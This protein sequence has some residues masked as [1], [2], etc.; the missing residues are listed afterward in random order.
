MKRALFAGAALI[1]LA[2]T[3]AAWADEAADREAIVRR[4][5]ERSQ[6]LE[7]THFTVPVEFY[8]QWLQ[9]V[10]EEAG[11]G[12]LPPV[13]YVDEL[14]DYRLAVPAEGPPTLRVTRRLRV[15]RPQGC[16]N[17]PL[18]SAE[19]SWSRVVVNGKA[20]EL[21]PL[22]GWLCLSPTEPGLVE[23]V[24]ELTLRSGNGDGGQATARVRPAVRNVLEFDSPQAW[25][26]HATGAIGNLV[27]DAEQGTRGRLAMTPSETLQVVYGRPK[28]KYERTPRYEVR[29][30]VAWNF[31][32]AS[33]Q[34]AADLV[35]TVAD[36]RSDQIDLV[37]PSA[38]DR[39]T[40]TGPDVREVHSSSGAA[41]VFLRQKISG[42]TRLQV[43]CELPKRQGGLQSLALPVVR[44][45]QWTDG[46]LV[47]T[48]TAGG[49]EVVPESTSGLEPLALAD[50][51][52]SA[53]AMLA[54]KAVL[55]YRIA[56]R[57]SKVDVNIL[58][59]SAYALRET[60]ADIAH[61]QLLL[62]GDGTVLCKASFEIR[63]RTRQFLEVELPPGAVV[64]AA[65]VNEQTRPM[66]LMP[67]RPDVYLL[68]LERSTVSVE[69]LISF[70]VEIVCLYRIDRLGRGR[71]AL[72]VP[73]I[74]LP[75]AYA[76]AELYAPDNLSRPQWSGPLERVD[77]YASKT[78]KATLGYGR[79]E[80]AAGGT[81]FK[82]VDIQGTPPVTDE[83]QSG[84]GSRLNLSGVDLPTS[85]L[86]ARNYYRAGK[87]FYDKGEFNKAVEAFRKTVELAPESVYAGN[88]ALYMG[89]AA[90]PE[91]WSQDGDDVSKK[92]AMQQVKED[93]SA[94]NLK[95][96][97]QQ[98]EFL[99]QGRQAAQTGKAAEAVEQFRAAVALGEKLVARGESKRE[100]D[101][102]LR[103]V[104]ARLAEVDR[105]VAAQTEQMWARV[106]QLK[107]QGRYEEALNTIRQMR[108]TVQS[109][110][111]TGGGSTSLFTGEDADGDRINREL[112]ELVVKAAGAQGKGASK[113][114]VLTQNEMNRLLTQQ[115]STAP[116]TEGSVETREV[117]RGMLPLTARVYTYPN[118]EEWRDLT[119]RRRRMV[120][121]DEKAVEL[122]QLTPEL[123]ERL[124]RLGVV[125]GDQGLRSV[126]PGDAQRG[127]Q[128]QEQDQE[129]RELVRDR[130]GRAGNGQI[131]AVQDALRD[132][133]PTQPAAA[134]HE[135][136]PT[137]LHRVDGNIDQAKKLVMD[138]LDAAPGGR[139]TKPGIDDGRPTVAVSH[140]SL[141][142]KGTGEQ[143]RQVEALIEKLQAAQGPQV[144]IGANI[145]TQ[146]AR[147]VIT[148]TADTGQGAASLD[149]RRP[150]VG[151]QGMDLT[152]N[153]TP[154]GSPQEQPAWNYT[155]LPPATAQP[156]PKLGDMPVMGTMFATDGN[157]AG[158]VAEDKQFQEFISRN[159]SWAMNGEVPSGQPSLRRPSG[160]SP[161][162]GFRTANQPVPGFGA[163]R[164]AL[165]GADGTMTI[166]VGGG[167]FIADSFEGRRGG[168]LRGGMGE[169][170][171]PSS[172]SP[173]FNQWY[174]DLRYWVAEEPEGEELVE[175]SIDHVDLSARYNVNFRSEGMMAFD[176]PAATSLP[177]AVRTTTA[178]ISTGELKGFLAGKAA[179][180]LGQKVP[181]NS[182]NLNVMVPEVRDLGI[183]FTSGNN[184]VSFTVIDEAQMRTLLELD[185][186]QDIERRV[187]GNNE[188]FQEAL[189][190]TDAQFA[191]GWTGNI[192]FGGEDY[193]TVN[194]IGNPINLPHEKYILVDN[195]RYLTAIRAGE[196]QHWT[197]KIDAAGIRFAEVP[198]TIDVPHVGQFI[199]FEKRL[200]KP[201][202]RL[203]IHCD[204]VWKGATE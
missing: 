77:E 150:V 193:N 39:V 14:A 141:V 37:L 69:G 139:V 67:G 145:I 99:E 33:Q 167:G 197:E 129:V 102:L 151:G 48:S 80:K 8:R 55:A 5:L 187:I 110:G 54:G 170:P 53:S 199:K 203:A 91:G 122:E 86:L 201:T 176:Q 153:V 22:D 133:K 11:Q 161:S 137:V 6:L 18:V 44:D 185:A 70:P 78:A 43:R 40:V 76:W 117:I 144:E 162:F 142:V 140:G 9:R 169:S 202:D 95:L 194:V 79:A 64:L 97:Q 2:A 109:Q 52:E 4:L 101:A 66:S 50:V 17:V 16:R 92:A 26:V 177:Q 30:D 130:S 47:L 113:S 118:A 155:E 173:E 3:S 29:G 98:R 192:Q 87:G 108:A 28:V 120:E 13:D 189:V 45:G 107:S 158:K 57:S 105:S 15:F 93:I 38:A 154:A 46:T 10:A 159:Y 195:G 147:K 63:N 1:A 174:N 100:Q 191:N 132:G 51:G 163:G 83:P 164:V 20:A 104:E 166:N 21:T 121:G 68:P 65:R 146:R 123:R 131:N 73:Q 32:V 125:Q 178:P 126:V 85:S 172:G 82:E 198:Q 61:W 56:G 27:G 59:L 119:E 24:A 179:F 165:Q 60:L 143:Q 134:Y 72:P 89:N 136:M 188:S 135:D 7:D 168:D 36:G 148:E 204:Y 171:S 112:G 12:V 196:M 25:E 103:E 116:A 81:V 181:V 74:D 90:L 84:F 200:V 156:S 75:I 62:R 42:A 152:F 94:S 127:R 19:L 149:G 96:V 184:D 71:M 160:E 190:G 31:D 175:V 186:K 182:I 23:V 88:A 34:L 35:V 49:S 114:R 115:Q 111:G 183:E 128:A 180:N 138:L 58:D 157:L 124:S 41:R 106:D